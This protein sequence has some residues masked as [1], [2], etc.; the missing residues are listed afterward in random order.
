MHVA[1]PRSADHRR[2]RSPRRSRTWAPRTRSSR[3][4]VGRRQVR[5]PRRQ[6]G[7]RFGRHFHHRLRGPEPA[8][9]VSHDQERPYAA[10]SAARQVGH[11]AGSR[12]R[13]PPTSWIS[14]W[15][16]ETRLKTG[17]TLGKAA[18]TIL[19]E[20][21]RHR[22]AKTRR[23][24]A[25]RWEQLHHGCDCRQVPCNLRRQQSH[26]DTAWLAEFAIVSTTPGSPTRPAPPTN[27]M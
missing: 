18:I 15:R 19:P 26:A 12:W 24:A 7:S 13:L 25:R 3:R 5:H 8:V 23:I 2:G 11:R 14:S 21:A 20:A 22:P 6:R 16:T 1:K 10:G 17:D 4:S 27:W 9:A